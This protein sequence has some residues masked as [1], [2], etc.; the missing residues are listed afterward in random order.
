MKPVMRTAS[1]SGPTRLG[2]R[3]PAGSIAGRNESAA[4]SSAIPERRAGT[5]RDDAPDGYLLGSYLMAT[6][7]EP[8]SSTRPPTTVMEYRGGGM[9]SDYQ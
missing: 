6:A 4:P 9:P 5:R 3:R 7:P 2:S 8:S 1:G